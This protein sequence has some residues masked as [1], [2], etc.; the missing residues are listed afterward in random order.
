MTADDNAARRGLLWTI[1]GVVATIA[2]G[3]PALY[4]TLKERTPALT[5]EL[6][7]EANVFDLHKSLDNLEIIF[8]GEDIRR[9]EENL[10]I[11]T[12]TI[13]NDGPTTI[14]QSFYDE[15]EPW[16]IAVTD[17]RLVAAPRIIDSN[18]DYLREK[19][20]P[21]VVN[22]NNIQFQKVIIERGR[23]VALEMLL[24]HKANQAP[25]L[26]PF[27]KIAGIDTLLLTRRSPEPAAST[28]ME[29]VLTGSVWVHLSRLG[30]YAL[31][32]IV[33]IFLLVGLGKLTSIR[34]TRRHSKEQTARQGR[35]DEHFADLFNQMTPLDKE[36][37]LA[38]IHA[39]GGQQEPLSELKSILLAK[40]TVGRISE[41]KRF[42]DALSKSNIAGMFEVRE[43]LPDAMFTVQE[44]GSVSLPERTV[45]VVANLADFVIA[46]PIPDDMLP[47]AFGDMRYHPSFVR[48]RGARKGLDW[49]S[50]YYT[51][52]AV[53]Q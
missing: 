1:L 28:F 40:D 24:L 46:H 50:V 49:R 33:L 8:N 31:A 10:R 43:L 4:F 26:T 36:L 6:T 7:S 45:R 42:I 20:R 15:T 16:G 35:M 9:A 29:V 30:L 19:I 38:L 34:R 23:Y 53:Q 5:L 13:R 39:T 18:S 11:V 32:I 27:G 37:A 48:R 3:A 21:T 41:T 44:D 12:L 17:A 25:R 47:F 52:K 51:T 22:T 14:L 2:L